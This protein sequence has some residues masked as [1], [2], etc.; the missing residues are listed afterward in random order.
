MMKKFFSFLL[1]AALVAGGADMMAQ[2]TN[3]SKGKDKTAKT[4]TDNKKP[5]AGKD[6]PKKG[7]KT[8]PSAA[9]PSDPRANNEL[10][11]I[12]DGELF[13]GTIDYK[14]AVD[15]SVK[16]YENY[17][18]KANN[19]NAMPAQSAK[20]IP[21]GKVSQPVAPSKTAPTR[22]RER[23]TIYYMDHE[24]LAVVDNFASYQKN[25]GPLI[26]ALYRGPKEP[27]FFA[28]SDFDA[29]EFEK[30]GDELYERTDEVKT[31]AG[32]KATKYI[33]HIPGL[34]AELWVA[35]EFK[36]NCNAVPFIGLKHPVLEFDY[37]VKIKD[38]V[39]FR[40]HMVAVRIKKAKVEDAQVRPVRD[41]ERIPLEEMVKRIVDYRDNL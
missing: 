1:C 4:K 32:V 31:I 40:A 15:E 13:E 25:Q 37:E 11:G 27:Y 23:G 34:K 20:P 26:Q 6:N 16:G 2:S 41:G 18:R 35:E 8:N 7:N 30:S 38:E 28:E 29:Q 10:S 36:T 22:S 17:S 9:T 12:A 3:K 33:C 14:F 21:K 24:A 5:T 39:F 19:P